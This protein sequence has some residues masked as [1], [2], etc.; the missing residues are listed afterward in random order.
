[1]SFEWSKY[2]FRSIRT[3][4]DYAEIFI[5]DDTPSSPDRDTPPIV[6]PPVNARVA[7]LVDGA[8]YGGRVD[9]ITEGGLVVAAPDISLPLDRPVLVEWRDA[10]GLWQLPG[11]VTDSR[12]Y[13][14]PTTTVRPP[15]L[16]SA[17]RRPPAR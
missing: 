10:A 6:A 14:F 17:S 11:E 4:F 2:H 16:R 7:L 15:A 8:R 12:L 13:P 3:R 9:D 5:C 1:M